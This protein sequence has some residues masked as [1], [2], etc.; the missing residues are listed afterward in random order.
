[1]ASG[2]YAVGWWLTALSNRPSSAFQRLYG[3]D[4]G[5]TAIG[6]K[7]KHATGTAAGNWQNGP[8][9]FTVNGQTFNPGELTAKLTVLAPADQKSTV[10]QLALATNQEMPVIQIWDYTNVQFVNQKRFTNFPKT[11]QNGLLSNSA[12]VW[13]MQGYVQAK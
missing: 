5:F 7:V 12:G 10:Q 3:A 13:M 1:M 6:A 9:S 4:D 2:K 11:G 8:T